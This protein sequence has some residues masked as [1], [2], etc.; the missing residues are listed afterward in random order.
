V[1]H[2][3]VE[4]VGT[5]TVRILVQNHDRTTIDWKFTRKQT[6]RKLHYSIIRSRD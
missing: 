6:R 5:E 4:H 1:K 3:L 2:K